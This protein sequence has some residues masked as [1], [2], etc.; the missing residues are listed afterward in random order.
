MLD[1]SDTSM[2][3]AFGKRQSGRLS[4]FKVKKAVEQQEDVKFGQG[5]S[6]C[7]YLKSVYLS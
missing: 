5:F 2:P 6:V 3:N 7:A 4:S 1:N